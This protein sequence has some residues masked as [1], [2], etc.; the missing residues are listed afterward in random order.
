MTWE[1][2]SEIFALL[3]VQL[4]CTDADEAM[5]RAYYEALKDLEPEFIAMAAHR[6]ARATNPDGQA[7]F[8]KTAEWRQSASSVEA[9]RMAELR[10]RLRK[11][12][13]PLCAACNDTG[14]ELVENR[15]RRCGCVQLRRL[16][17][18]GRR[19][20]PALPEAR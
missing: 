3:A 11:M 7:W 14:W 19:P 17:I 12:P 6:L 15:A 18:L 10:G 16:E 13:E 1:R 2:F 8:P 9:D 4:R 5:A 20:M